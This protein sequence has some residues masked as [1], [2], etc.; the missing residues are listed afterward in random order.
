MTNFETVIDFGSKNLKVGIFD[1]NLNNIYSSEKEIKNDSEILNVEKSLNIL[2][3]DTEKNL[4]AHIDEVVVLFDSEKFYS[5]D[6]SIKKIFDQ[7]KLLKKVF[8]S[9]IDE[10]SFIVSQNNYKDQIIHLIVNNIVIDQNKKI[11]EIIDDI[12]IKSLILEIKFICINKTLISQLNSIFKKNNLK[13]SN[14][15][16]SSYIKTYSYKSKYNS[17][18]FIVFLDIGYERTNTLVFKDGKFEYFHTIPIGGNNVTKDISR[19]MNL[20]LDYSEKLKVFFNHKENNLLLNKEDK[21]YLNIFNEI[22]EK[23][24]SVDLLKQIIEA[25]LDEIIHLAT[26]KYFFIENQNQQEKPSLVFLA[27]VLNYYLVIII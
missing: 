8:D 14:L 6:I 2:I 23:N 11:S 24:I 5:L 17:K 21:S 18:N 1:Q 15:Y 4:S 12:K 25:R 27:E 10:A 9:L 26:K 16:C 20:N 19:V 13:I 3:R 22:S 7:P